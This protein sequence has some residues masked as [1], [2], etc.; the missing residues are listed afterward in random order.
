MALAFL[1]NG[2]ELVPEY[3]AIGGYEPVNVLKLWQGH[4]EFLL[5]FMITSPV[6]IAGI[7]YINCENQIQWLMN[8]VKQLMQG[9]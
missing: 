4:E 6:V 8:K 9:S 2:N 5:L 3:T 7:L 1:V